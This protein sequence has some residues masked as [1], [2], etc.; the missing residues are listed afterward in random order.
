[1]F[2]HRVGF[3]CLQILRPFLH[4][5]YFKWSHSYPTR[6]YGAI[7]ILHFNWIYNILICLFWEVAKICWFIVRKT[8]FVDES[9]EPRKYQ[10]RFGRSMVAIWGFKYPLAI[11][12]ASNKISFPF[13]LQAT[14]LR[15][16]MRK[17]SSSSSEA[18]SI[19]FLL[20]IQLSN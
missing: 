9:I 16:D 11:C 20:P 17:M 13:S 3:V 2:S 5:N 8:L 7:K 1:M 12:P 14:H 18:H 6:V 19:C 10:I 15:M 4:F